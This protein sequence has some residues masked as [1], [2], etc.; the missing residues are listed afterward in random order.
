MTNQYSYAEDFATKIPEVSHKKTATPNISSA[1]K[2]YMINRMQKE[3]AANNYRSG[4]NNGQKY[5]TSEDFVTYFRSRQEAS[6]VKANVATAQSAK[7]T[8]ASA[9]KQMS[10]AKENKPGEI[11]R[12]AS[13]KMPTRENVARNSQPRSNIAEAVRINKNA[14]TRTSAKEDV[15]IYVPSVKAKKN[16]E[17]RVFSAINADN[18]DRIKAVANDWMP[19]EEIVAAKNVKKGKSFRGMLLGIAGVAVSLMLIV[20]GSVMLN[21][22]RRDVKAL[23]N[24]ARAL[25]QEE[26]LLKLELDIKND[27]NVLRDKATTELGMIDKEYVEACYL[28]TMGAD[29]IQSHE[30]ERSDGIGFSTILSA[31]GIN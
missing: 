10:S 2:I 24:E 14:P 6:P 20:S 12:S 1:A 21:D 11:L 15:K 18:L 9:P 17:T 4:N 19:K 29:R 28:N 31:F 22:A 23:E 8:S 13:G 7:T 26:E 16:F 5:M 30:S 25:Q 3:N 27:I